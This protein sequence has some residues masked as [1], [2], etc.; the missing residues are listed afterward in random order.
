MLI[1]GSAPVAQEWVRFVYGPLGG[2]LIRGVCE[3]VAFSWS[4]V[5][6]VLAAGAG[7]SIL[8]VMNR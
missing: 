8:G 7:K 2:V 5:V 6:S 4:A 1:L 3:S